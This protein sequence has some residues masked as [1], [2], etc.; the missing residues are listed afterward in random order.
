MARGQQEV[1][2]GGPHGY[3]WVPHDGE[4]KPCLEC[5]TG[6]CG[7]TDMGRADDGTRILWALCGPCGGE[8]EVTNAWAQHE[9]ER[10]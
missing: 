3:Q 10:H 8:V 4:S 2:V 9:A 1:C 6:T 7:V 5:N